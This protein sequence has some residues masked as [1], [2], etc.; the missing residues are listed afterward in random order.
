[1]TS[2]QDAKYREAITG[3]CLL[4]LGSAVL[5][6][7]MLFVNGSLVWALLAAFAKSGPSWTSK[8]EVSQFLLFLVPVLLV[9]AEWMMID[10]V[11]SRFWS[12]AN[13]ESDD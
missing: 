3:G 12:P 4:A 8:P 11:R 2:A 6:C 9:M 5:T 10:Y 13:Q 1:M 7:F